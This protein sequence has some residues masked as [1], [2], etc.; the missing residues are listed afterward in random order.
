[1]LRLAR[2]KGEVRVVNDIVMSPTATADVADMALTLIERQS[3]PGVYHAVNSGQ[4]TWY[5]F[6]R[7]II[8]RVGIGARTIPVT[9][10]EFPTVARRPSYSVLDNRKVSEV[11]GSVPHWTGALDRYLRAKGHV[12]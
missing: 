5:E 6:A 12:H 2:E 11:V 8:S 1:M 4:A 3:E 10:A 7:E 9:G